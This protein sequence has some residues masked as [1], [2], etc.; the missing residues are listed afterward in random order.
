MI[1]L[2]DSELEIIRMELA[3]RFAAAHLPVSNIR[4]TGTKTRILEFAEGLLHSG[5]VETCNGTNLTYTGVVRALE[6]GFNIDIPNLHLQGHQ[7]RDRK[8][9]AAQFLRRL[10]ELVEKKADEML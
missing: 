1:E 2:F 7:S 9:G 8:R 3:E 4:W 5:E 6:L 10:A